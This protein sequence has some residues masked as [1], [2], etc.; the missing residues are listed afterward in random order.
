M[1][2]DI[3]IELEEVK[4]VEK[5]QASITKFIVNIGRWLLFLLPIAL[6]I[7]TILTIFL[8]PQLPEASKFAEETLGYQ[9]LTI[10][11][12][13]VLAFYFIN[14]IILFLGS[15][16]TKKSLEMRLGYERRKGRPIDSLDGF[17]LL[18]DNVNRVLTIMDITSL[19]CIASVGLFAVMLLLGDVGLSYI[20]MGTT[21]VGLGL[22]LLI[23]SLNLNIN[24]VNG[25]QEFFKPLT[26]Q[27][28]LD[29]YF[30][31]VFANHLDPVT[32]LKWDEYKLGLKEILT[33]Q[34]KEMINGKEKGEL[35]ITFAIEKILFLYYLRYQGVISEDQLKQ[36]FREVIDIDSENFDIE[37]G[38]LIE[39][40]W[41]F[42]EKDIYKLFKFIKRYNPGFFTLMDRLQLELADNIEQIS[43]DPI[44]MDTSA[45]EVVFLNSELNIMVFLY[46]NSVDSKDYRIRIAAP[47]FEPKK[48]SLNIKVEGRGNFIIPDHD[49]PLVSDEGLDITQVLSSM[50]ENGDTAWTTLEPIKKGEQTIQIFLETSEGEIIEGE[51]KT[52]KI[53]RDIKDYLKKISSLGS[54][55]SGVAVAASRLLVS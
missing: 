12:V 37:K 48:V 6:I 29:N 35:P 4:K 51:T 25:L 2:Q 1:E 21:F 42:A 54:V 11:Y 7:I 34:F 19:V 13:I 39:Q 45:Q 44:Y 30:A 43:K 17:E 53:K 38:F 47:G 36:E 49:I 18:R 55:V 46:N 8:F 27:I 15:V 9:T 23:R 20:A 52:I 3:E 16:R 33:P 22:A 31:E 50:L 28:F 26:H 10:I 5:K 14:S 41:Y 24:D 40:A 32:Y